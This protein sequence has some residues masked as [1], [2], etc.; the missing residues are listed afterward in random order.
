MTESN[1]HSKFTCREP[2]FSK[3]QDHADDAQAG[4]ADML[5]QLPAWLAGRR[6]F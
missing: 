2:N 5:A 4:G 6:T 3:E 1:L